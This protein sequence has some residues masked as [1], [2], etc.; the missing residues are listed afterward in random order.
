MTADN[1]ASLLSDQELLGRFVDRQ[2]RAAVAALVKRHGPM[3]RGVCMRLLRRESDAD[4]AFQATFLILLRQARSIRKRRSLGSWLYGVAFRTAQKAKTDA[5]QRRARERQVKSTSPD[6]PWREVA[7]REICATLDEELQALSEQYRAPLVLCYLEG[8]TRDETAQ[9]LG[10]SLRTLQR[11]MERGRE[12]LRARLTRRG[13]TLSIGLLASALSEHGTAAPLPAPLLNL[14]VKAVLSLTGRAAAAGL[15]SGP[16]AALAKEVLKAMYISK[17][18]TLATIL[19]AAALGVTGAGLCSFRTTAAEQADNN[20]EALATFAQQT[21]TKE[22]KATAPPVEHGEELPP[23]IRVPSQRDGIVRVI[24]TG[25]KEGE[26]VPPERT[27]TVKIGGESKKYR[28]LKKGDSVEEGQL[29]ALLDDDL[30]R[31]E[32]AIKEAKVWAAEAEKMTSEMARDEALSRYETQKK[33]Y[34]NN[35]GGIRATSKEDMTG[36]LLTYNKYVEETKTKEPAIRVAKQE[37]N[38]A[39]KI[40]EMHEIRSPSRGVIKAI[41]KRP[42]EAVKALDTVFLIQVPQD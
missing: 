31:A 20:A 36:A 22:R 35:V 17:L 42:G 12:I 14:T 15:S 10:W 26:K 6:E 25:I 2:D 40:L 27:I 18:T 33:L 21:D 11:R 3:V 9:Q 38:Q 41:Y 29:L 8:R 34:Y 1:Q 39:R 37:L 23:V 5:A 24:G 7:W 13:L 4:D 32:V 28:R 30:A 19:V 16:A